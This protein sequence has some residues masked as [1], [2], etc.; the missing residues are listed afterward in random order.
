MP[1]SG[2]AKQRIRS[3]RFIASQWRSMTI[4][5][6]DPQG[7]VLRLKK[8]ALVWFFIG[9]VSQRSKKIYL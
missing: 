6:S 4:M 9:N 8:L 2:H 3:D 5:D 1:N 7:W